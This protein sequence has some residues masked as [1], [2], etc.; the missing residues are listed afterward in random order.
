MTTYTVGLTRSN[1]VDRPLDRWIPRHGNGK[2][3]V[4]LDCGLDHG[5]AAVSGIT[6]DQDVGAGPGADDS[7]LGELNEV[8]L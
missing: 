3:G 5:V 6:P 4:A 8:Q 7:E 1:A 2:H